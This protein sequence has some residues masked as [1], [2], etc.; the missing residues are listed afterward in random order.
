MQY[1]YQ[2]YTGESLPCTD[3]VD[4]AVDTAATAQNANGMAYRYFRIAVS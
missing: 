3:L 4:H 1:C 2:H